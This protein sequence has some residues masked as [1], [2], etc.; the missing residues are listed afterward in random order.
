MSRTYMGKSFPHTRWSLIVRIREGDEQESEE[1]LDSICQDYWLPLYSFLRLKGEAPAAAEDIVQGFFLDMLSRGGF[2]KVELPENESGNKLRSFLLTCLKNYRAKTYRADT[3]QKRGGSEPPV[4]IDT[5]MA[6]NRLADLSGNR[7][8]PEKAYDQAWALNLIRNA[9]SRVEQDY[10]GRGK[11]EVFRA[12]GPLL[13]W[14][15]T[16]GETTYAEVA[17]SLGVNEQAVK[18]G[19]HRLRKRIREAI[20]K[21]IARTIDTEGGGD[22]DE[23]LAALFAVL[24]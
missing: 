15:A 19:V 6:E 14:N 9:T 3:A 10:A 20:K 18:T 7:N 2:A 17:A 4:A 16:S 21:E 13:A 22:V 11:A 24:A 1:A 12:F 8:D 5:E 23:E